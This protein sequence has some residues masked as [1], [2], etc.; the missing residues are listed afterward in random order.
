MIGGNRVVPW[1]IEKDTRILRR[2][3]ET[4]IEGTIYDTERER[5]EWRKKDC[6]RKS[7]GVGTTCTLKKERRSDEDSIV[8]VRTRE[9][10]L[11]EWLN[12]REG[13]KSLQR[14]RKRKKAWNEEKEG[15]ME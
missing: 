9:R 13:K 8:G 5:E 10:E 3:T 7:V 2:R 15:T 1:N 14:V 6:A 4:E 12:E 11:T